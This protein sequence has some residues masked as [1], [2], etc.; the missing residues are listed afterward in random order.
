MDRKKQLNKNEIDWIL[1]LGLKN[2][3]V[4]KIAKLLEAIIIIF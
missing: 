4:T 2:Y 3:T 1:L